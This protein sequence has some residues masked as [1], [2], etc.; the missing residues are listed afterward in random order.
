MPKKKQ[1][2]VKVNVS[3]PQDLADWLNGKVKD[4][5]YASISHGIRLCVQIVRK[6]GEL[7]K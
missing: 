1:F 2:E 3:L 6:Q 7:L 4:G 5:T